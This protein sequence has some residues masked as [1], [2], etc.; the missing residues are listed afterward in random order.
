M[1]VKKK[2]RLLNKVRRIFPEWALV[3]Q[4]RVIERAFDDDLL[5]AKDD[6]KAFFMAEAMRDNEAS[7]YWMALQERRSLK[8]SRRA[9][10]LHIAQGNLKWERDA[11]G[12]R[13]LEDG[14][15]TGLIGTIIGLVAI[16]KK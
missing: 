6:P 7:E 8:L 10:K 11:Y 16:W 15:L 14:A 1:D 13:Y 5:N 9:R 2:I 3:R 4:A 12:N